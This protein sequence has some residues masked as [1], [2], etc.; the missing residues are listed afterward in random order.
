MDGDP[1]ARDFLRSLESRVGRR[2]C[3]FCRSRAWITVSAPG[4]V[5]G[6]G[7]DSSIEVATLIC[8]H[9]YFVRAHVM[10]PRWHEAIAE[11]L[12]K[13]SSAPREG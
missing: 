5:P 2:P 8:G 10:D 3:P 13:G 12:A 4:F 9:C 7:T 6:E 1:G 11:A